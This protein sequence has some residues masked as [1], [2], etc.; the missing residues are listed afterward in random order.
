MNR[1]GAKLT[2]VSLL[3]VLLAVL[4]AALLAYLTPEGGGIIEDGDWTPTVE[5]GRLPGM[6]DA[7]INNDGMYFFYQV[8][9][10][11]TFP[12][13]TAAGTISLENTPGNLYNMEVEYYS[14]EHGTIYYSP[15]LA[16]GTYLL[17]DKLS[18]ELPEGVYPAEARIHILDPDTGEEQDVFIE[19]ISVIV[20]NTLF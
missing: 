4:M 8:G 18:V 20:K 5:E 15:T 14:E 2:L 13:P 12:K 9:K 10:E 1:S 7:N 19:N 17:K 16:P 6:E 3:V 11:V